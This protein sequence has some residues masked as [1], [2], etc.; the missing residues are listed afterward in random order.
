MEII[1]RIAIP[2][3]N[4]VKLN[5]V[6][7]SSEI[8]NPDDRRFNSIRAAGG[9][10]QEGSQVFKNT[11]TF[12]MQLFTSF[13]VHLA[14]LLTKEEAQKFFDGDSYTPTDT[15]AVAKVKDYT[16]L[17]YHA[18][19]FAL[20]IGDKLAIYFTS[21]FTYT[22][23]TYGT[24]ADEID[25]EGNLPE[26]TSNYV[27][28]TVS[29]TIIFSGGGTVVKT[30]SITAIGFDT[31]SGSMA[32]V[33]DI[34]YTDLTS[35]TAKVSLTYDEKDF[36]LYG[37]AVD[38]ASLDDFYFIAVTETTGTKVVKYLSEPLEVYS[39]IPDR[40]TNI[41]VGYKSSGSYDPT[42]VNGYYYEG[43]YYNYSRLLGDFHLMDA[44]GEIVIFDEERTS[45]KLKAF[46]YTDITFRSFGIT[47]YQLTN[48]LEIFSH[49][50]IKINEYLWTNLDLG[51]AENIDG[52]DL[53]NFEV[54]LRQIQDNKFS[55]HSETETILAGF[56]P[57]TDNF[58]SDGE[59]QNYVFA[60]DIAT[61]FIMILK[62][63]WISL[64]SSTISDG[65]TVQA[66]ASENTGGTPRSGDVLFRSVQYPELEA[67]FE[68][69]QDAPTTGGDY[70]EV[71]SNDIDVD[72]EGQTETIT[73]NSSGAWSVDDALIP[74][75][76]TIGN[77]TATTFDIIFTSNLHG[78]NDR[79]GSVRVELDSDPGVTY[80]DITID[81]TNIPSITSWSPNSQVISSSAITL[82]P[83]L[84]ADS[85]C[86]WQI[87]VSVNGT[88]IHP[89]VTS[90]TGTFISL[91]INVD[92]NPGSYRVATVI[93]KNTLNPG[94]TKTFIITQS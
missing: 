72:W 42:D 4:V 7:T 74:S 64:D 46:P 78:T 6:Y 17:E 20:S 28:A 22:D 76:I 39:S 34:D 40:L 52:T 92:Y 41:Q 59:A 80:Q 71:S 47:G 53:Y 79:S 19:C 21:G 83:D 24:T 14:E 27:G 93:A 33:T 15:F 90:G 23:N 1:S 45:T 85:T 84:N 51:S 55:E 3:S 16:G 32:L 58:I 66:T 70:L 89:A 8:K 57:S 38:F 61:N 69:T 5:R 12:T 86:A 36:D 10:Y 35:Q 30:G 75:G 37:F 50:T 13:D 63:A 29:I 9:L 49:D 91:T 94:N 31:V 68:V 2:K 88:W 56:T 73:V 54:K 77:V 81:Q 67:S 82:T 65:D 62:P 18:D 25:L 87:E 11:D 43:S 60:A 44:S 48:L 26:V